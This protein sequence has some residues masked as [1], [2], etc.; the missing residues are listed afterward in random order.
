[1]NKTELK[2][3]N[4]LVKQGHH[5]QITNA[6]N[7]PDLIT[8]DG[9]GYEVKLL[10]GGTITF[11]PGQLKVLKSSPYNVIVLV[12]RKDD[13]EPYKVIPISDI[14]DGKFIDKT[15][16]IRAGS[17]TSHISVP[18]SKEERYIIRL[19]S[20]S[21]NKKPSEIVREA[22]LDWVMKSSESNKLANLIT[23]EVND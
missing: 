8:D 13:I 14:S 17:I 20:V 21:T 9:K 2:A 1:M 19:M 4:W 7:S 3:Y 10:R 5:I 12:F 6:I 11:S 15:C 16:T 22:I 18:M 23:K